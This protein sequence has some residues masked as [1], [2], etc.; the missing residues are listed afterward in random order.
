[1]S[2]VSKV[3]LFQFDLYT[4][5]SRVVEFLASSVVHKEPVL[6]V[7]ETGVGKT[8]AIQ[9]LSNLMVIKLALWKLKNF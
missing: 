8:S 4:K 3:K 1:M 9:Y 6:L 7:G 5:A 2:F